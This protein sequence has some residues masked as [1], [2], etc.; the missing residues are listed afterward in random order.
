MRLSVLS[1]VLSKSAEI[2]R[3]MFGGAI[4]AIR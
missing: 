4:P 3:R 2:V 1:L